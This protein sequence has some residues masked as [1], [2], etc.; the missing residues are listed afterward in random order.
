ML[1]ADGASHVAHAVWYSAAPRAKT[2]RSPTTSAERHQSQVAAIQAPV[3]LALA[4]PA[5]DVD[6]QVQVWTVQL[7]L[8]QGDHDAML[9]MLTA[10]PA[11]STMERT[12]RGS[13]HG[14]RSWLGTS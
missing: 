7:A 1:G 11:M 4:A 13:G 6:A 2:E 10:S 3:A 8:E 14:S 9:N 5:A 12:P